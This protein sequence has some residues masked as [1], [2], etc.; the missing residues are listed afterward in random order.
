MK[1]FSKQAS[2]LVR[3]GFAL[4]CAVI[5]ITANDAEA[6]EVRY[7]G[8]EQT[9]YVK[10]GEPTQISFPSKI[11]GGFKRKNSSVKLER[12]ENYLVM[13][14]RPDLLPEGEAIIVHLD[15]RRTY[16]IRV[17][18]SSQSYPRDSKVTIIDDTLPE[19]EVEEEAINQNAPRRFAPPSVISG[20]VREMILVAEFGNR[21]GINGYKRSNRY[22]GEVVY[23]DGSLKATIDEIFMGP[24]LWG[25][26]INVENLLDTAQRINPAT[27][28]MDG[29][30]A[31]TAENWELA[32]RPVT[33][34]QKLANTHLGKVY[35]V[36]RS[37]RR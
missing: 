19:V 3:Y 18:P 34:E 10:P 37:R 16:S 6:R 23:H 24:N 8:S 1:G 4:C 26:V 15:D 20:L 30:R 21:K 31:I 35:V 9:V 22:S 36:T 28:R 11:S 32:P 14:A 33:A 25:Y 17:R 2:I 12:Q 13:F 29:T 5:A 7:D 27:F